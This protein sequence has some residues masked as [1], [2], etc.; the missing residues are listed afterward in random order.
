MRQQ[1]RA[2]RMRAPR[3]LV[4]TL[5]LAHRLT[6]T[7]SARQI[8]PRCVRP[9][10]VCICAAL[11]SAPIETATRVLVLRHER[12]K[13]DKKVVSTVPLI[14]MCLRQCSVVE[15]VEDAVDILRQSVDEGCSPLLLFPAEGARA[16]DGMGDAAGQSLGGSRDIADPSDAESAI[17][18]SSSRDPSPSTDRSPSTDP[19]ASKNPPS[20]IDPSSSSSP[21]LI[22]LVDGTWRQAKQLVRALPPHLFGAPGETAQTAAATPL[23][24]P[25]ATPLDPLT[26][27]PLDP[28]T[29]TPLDPLTTTPLDPPTATHLDR[30]TPLDPPLIPVA[31][32]SAT[33]SAFDAVRKEPAP[34]CMSTLEA[35]ARALRILDPGE[36]AAAAA[37]H[38]EVGRS[39]SLTPP[40][41]ACAPTV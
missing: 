38:M 40:L 1:Q 26:A 16:L 7:R 29:A 9:I 31:F 4:L 2:A 14:Q 35:C 20:S 6:P 28:P 30:P 39:A 17:D 27:T 21:Y 19:S 13:R 8:C 3:L 15:T 5:V 18:P 24:P 12:E 41:H 22:F 32:A 34:H 37:A 25:T 33:T 10:S 23:D 11:P 36:E